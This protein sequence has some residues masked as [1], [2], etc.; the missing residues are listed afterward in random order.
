MKKLRLV[1]DGKRAAISSVSG[2]GR[3]LLNNA[4]FVLASTNKLSYSLCRRVFSYRGEYSEGQKVSGF[5]LSPFPT[6]P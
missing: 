2:E 5:L 4:C 1:R 3:S 6:P